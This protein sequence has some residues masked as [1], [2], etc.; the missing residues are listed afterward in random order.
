M[1]YSIRLIPILGFMVGLNYL[2]FSGGESEYDNLDVDTLGSR[3][4]LQIGIGL[5]IIQIV[6]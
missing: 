1:N 3:K 2:D 5:F 6:W 4:E